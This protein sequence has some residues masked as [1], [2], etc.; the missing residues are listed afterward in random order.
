MSQRLEVLKSRISEHF[1]YGSRRM[2]AV[3]LDVKY[4][5]FTALLILH[6]VMSLSA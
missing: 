1:F 2:T 5:S 4:N 6:N 3:D